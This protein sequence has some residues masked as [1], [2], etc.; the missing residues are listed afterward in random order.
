MRVRKEHCHGLWVI[1]CFSIL[2]SLFVRKWSR[3]RTP[4]AR[5]KPARRPSIAHV[6]DCA[7]SHAEQVVVICGRCSFVAHGA[8]VEVQSSKQ[9]AVYQNLKSAVHGSCGHPAAVD[10]KMCAELFYG[11]VSA[12]AL[13]RGEY[14]IAL[15]GTSAVCASQILGEHLR[16][17]AVFDIVGCHGL[18]LWRL[19]ARKFT[20]IFHSLS[21]ND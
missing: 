14:H 8:I 17:C 20:K 11:E 15:C 6:F 7:A 12:H 19:I 21:K 9:P 4:S 5:N 2:V 1:F 18:S 16:R 3:C 10:D 13:G